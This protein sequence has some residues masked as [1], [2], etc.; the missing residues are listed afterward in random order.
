MNKAEIQA[1]SVGVGACR[2]GA[3]RLRSLQARSSTRSLA[4]KV[5]NL[6]TCGQINPFVLPSLCPFLPSSCVCTLDVA[7]VLSC[8]YDRS[9][10]CSTKTRCVPR[11]AHMGS[12]AP[13]RVTSFTFGFPQPDDIAKHQSRSVEPHI[14]CYCIKIRSVGAQH[15]PCI[16]IPYALYHQVIEGLARVHTACCIHMRNTSKSYAREILH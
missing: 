12:H 16:Q 11:G 15:K 8:A 4:A 7:G 13:P 9:A 14:C 5:M 10:A 6:A 3:S 1:P 2:T